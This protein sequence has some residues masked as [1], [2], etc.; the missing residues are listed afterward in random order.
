LAVAKHAVRGEKD[1]GATSALGAT[2]CVTPS[3]VWGAA[4][5]EAS[6]LFE[7]RAMIACIIEYGVRPGMED[8][9]GEAFAALVPEIQRIDGFISMDNFQSQTR[10]G[11]MLEISYWRDE[12]ALQSWI[13]N[14]A[15]RELMLRGRKEIFSWYKISSTEIKRQIDWTREA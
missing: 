2:A 1:P 14:A 7:E 3:S 8:K 10:P 12:R 5:R 15:H 11:A 13:D 4:R 9:L 6:G